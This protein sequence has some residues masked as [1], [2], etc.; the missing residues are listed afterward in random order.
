MSSQDLSLFSSLPSCSRSQ[1]NG[2]EL[3]LSSVAIVYTHRSV[4]SVAFK[5]NQRRSW[6]EFGLGFD[7]VFLL[8][9]L[10]PKTIGIRNTAAS[11]GSPYSSAVACLCVSLMEFP[12]AFINR[13]VL[14]K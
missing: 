4:V 14:G 9:N 13:E 7:V 10:Q 6:Y 3:I 5:M 1:I 8:L 2:T 11:Y 12:T